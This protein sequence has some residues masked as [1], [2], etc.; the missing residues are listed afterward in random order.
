MHVT[1]PP[2]IPFMTF[3]AD[4]G[5]FTRSRAFAATCAARGVYLHPHHNWFLS[6]ALTETDMA[7][8]LDVTDVAF[9]EAVRAASES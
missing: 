6:A 9:G 8:V 2:A 7:R 3:V 5:S 1:G 4:A